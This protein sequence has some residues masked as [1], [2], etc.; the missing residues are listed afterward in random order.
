[1]SRLADPSAVE[2]VALGPCQCP[3]T[4]H[5]QD[6]A[7]VR[8]Q[9]GASALARVGMAELS[10]SKGD[11][12]ASWRQLITEATVRW[13]LLTEYEGK[14]VPVP[15]APATVAE[16]DE[17]TLTTLATAIDDLIQQKGILPNASGAPSV[18]SP[19]GSASPI[20]PSTPTPGT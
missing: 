16:L 5:E 10:V 1:M 12:Y 7:V 13:N 3:G 20:P 19:H 11:V 8:W 18:A 2:T 6:E 15:V 17:D 9:L 14:V 4:P